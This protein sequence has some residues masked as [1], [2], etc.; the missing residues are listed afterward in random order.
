CASEL[1]YCRLG[2]GGWRFCRCAVVPLNMRRTCD[3][4]VCSR[5]VCAV[6]RTGGRNLDPICG[7]RIPDL[8]YRGVTPYLARIWDPE[9]TPNGDEIG[10]GDH[11]NEERQA[12]R[13]RYCARKRLGDERAL[14]RHRAPVLPRGGAPPPRT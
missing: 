7:F 14:G 3:L 4:G 9:S 12:P 5:L 10:E 13:A 6:R 11:G 8:L 2:A 1:V